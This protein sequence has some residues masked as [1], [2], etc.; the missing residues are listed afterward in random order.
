MVTIDTVVSTGQPVVTSQV[1]MQV[2][3]NSSANTTNPFAMI[4]STSQGASG[5]PTCH[6]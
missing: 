4:T 1:L 3:T 2:M 5:C 6:E